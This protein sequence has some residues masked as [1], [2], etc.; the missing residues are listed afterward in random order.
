M[1]NAKAAQDVADAQTRKSADQLAD[2]KMPS[3]IQ[4]TPAAGEGV[5][6]QVR[7]SCAALLLCEVMTVLCRAAL[8]VCLFRVCVCVC[9]CVCV[10]V[11][12]LT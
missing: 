10:H 8:F 12:L 1:L 5:R 3:N 9:L 2:E 11:C 4:I 6:R 7:V